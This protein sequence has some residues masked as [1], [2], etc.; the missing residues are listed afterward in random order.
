[1]K[2]LYF[3]MVMLISQLALGQNQAPV[4]VNDTL[5]IYH[6]DSIYKAVFQIMNNDFDSNGDTLAFDT[7]SYN[8]TNQVGFVK[9]TVNHFRFSRIIFK[10]NPVFQVGIPYNIL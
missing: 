1:M 5:I 6:E 8:G 7:I 3:I 2:K 10:A 4:A 9:I